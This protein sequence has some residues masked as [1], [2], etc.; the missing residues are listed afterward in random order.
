[1]NELEGAC[2]DQE[3]S[4]MKVCRIISRYIIVRKAGPPVF[5]LLSY[6]VNINTIC[7]SNSYIVCSFSSA[8]SSLHTG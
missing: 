6:W 5:T 1:M 2:S 7:N 4:D 8:L 3:N